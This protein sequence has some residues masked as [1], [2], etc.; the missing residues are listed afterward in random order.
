MNE[1]IFLNLILFIIKQHNC[2]V[3]WNRT[4]IESFHFVIEGSYDKKI[5]LIP[6]LEHLMSSMENKYI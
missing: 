3:D 2:F 6:K 1:T 4:D 5:K